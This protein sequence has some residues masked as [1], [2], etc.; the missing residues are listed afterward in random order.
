MSV[1]LGVIGIRSI[2]SN[3]ML[4]LSRISAQNAGSLPSL[5]A[6]S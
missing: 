6:G 4:P 3:S 5:S 2:K 1:Q